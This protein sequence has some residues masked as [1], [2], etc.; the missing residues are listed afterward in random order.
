MNKQ[1]YLGSSGIRDYLT[2]NHERYIPLIEL[3]AEL[4]PYLEPYDV[5][6][7]VKLMNTLPLGNVKSLPAWNL[8]QADAVKGS[9]IVESSSGNTV[10]SM[11]LLAQHAGAKSVT[12][13]ASNDVSVP[14]LNLLRLAGIGVQLHTGPICPDPNDPTSTI[15]IARSKGEQEGWYSP[16]QYD[17]DANPAAHEMIT[18]PQLY[19]QLGDS[20]GLFV[21]GLGTTGTLFGT[22]RYLRHQLPDLSVAG[23]TRVPNNLV[24]GVRTRNGLHEIAF[25]WQS[26]LTEEPI[27][28]NEH[29]SYAASLALIRQGLLVGPSAGF[30]YQ[31]LL[32]VLESYV[33]SGKITQL[34]GKHA[35]FIAPDSCFPYVSDYFEVL[36]D[37]AFPAIDDHTDGKQYQEADYQLA[38]IPE[39]SVDDVYA[40]Y[41]TDG[42]Y[43]VR[44]RHY[45]L[46]D[47]RS[48]QEFLD[49]SLPGSINV[50]LADIPE[51]LEQAKV[52]ATYVFV[53][54]RVGLS[55]RAAQAAMQRGLASYIM[56]GGTAAWSARGY[57]RTT[58]TTC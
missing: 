12:A 52:K 11:G 40:D 32:R 15:A 33:K 54:R 44:S 16:G 19:D 51:W 49:H 46:V 18:G 42:G 22:A 41:E 57:E 29:D 14:K 28:V 9:H 27:M 47:V 25:N 2:P 20:L 37:D 48:P 43:L 7:S 24:P 34:A 17:N 8:L 35:V 50:P 55:V 58:P 30:A 6:I 31:G 10:F 23:V 39:L 21:A 1:T 36:G 53:C 4:N 38:N 26:V 45:I 56:T 13:I 5:H 3:P